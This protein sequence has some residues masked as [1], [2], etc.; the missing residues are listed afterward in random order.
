MNTKDKK[1]IF[2]GSPKISAFVLEHLI[3][4][5]YNIVGCVTKA[6]KR[7]KRGNEL[8]PSFVAQVCSKY[9]IPCHKPIKLNNDY[10][11][12][13]EKD[14]DL[15][16]TF[17]YGQIISEGILNLSKYKPLNIHPSYLPMYRGASPIQFALRDGLDKTGVSLQEMAKKMDEGDV[18]ATID[19]DIDRE[20]NFTSL[21]EKIEVKICE[22]LDTYLDL[23]LENKL[24]G[25]KQDNDKATYTR[26]IKSDEEH[27]PL[28]LTCSKFVN[29][30]RSFADEIGPYLLQENNEQLKIYKCELYSDE[31]IGELGQI[32]IKNKKVL[33]QLSDG[34]VSL[35]ILQKPGKKVLNAIDFLNGSRDFDK[36]ILH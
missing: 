21:C 20:D 15:L 26:L 22:L 1:I 12:I 17:A 36:R 4:K 31:H 33:L 14:P 8:V 2:L 34:L 23:Y 28:S 3:N 19:V 13:K 5:G 27:I 11:F 9:N 29:Y 32:F 30:V 35:L 25:I 10:D 6:D 18:F 16:L 24:V 7:G